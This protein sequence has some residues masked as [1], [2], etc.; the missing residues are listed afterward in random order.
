MTLAAD[1]DTW[2]DTIATATSLPATRDPKKVTGGVIYIGS[3]ST[4]S[5]T[6]PAVVLEVPCYLVA[7]G[8]GKP[9]A[10]WLLDNLLAFLAAIGAKSATSEQLPINGGEYPCLQSPA[11][12][13]ITQESPCL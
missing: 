13:H 11:R 10:D 5:E 3:P 9:A 2:T 1:L 4:V 7:A 12:L 8:N 6:L